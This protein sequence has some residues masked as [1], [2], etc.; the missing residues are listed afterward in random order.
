MQYLKK[1]ITFSAACVIAICCNVH[2]QAK[3]TN[4]SNFDVS[5]VS[6]ITAEELFEHAPKWCDLETC[7]LIIN[8][9][10]EYG[11][12]SEFAISVFT[13][14]YVPERNSVGGWKNENGSYAAY[15]S[16]QQSI[17]SWYENMSETYLNQESWHYSLTGSTLIK[18]IA[19]VYCQGSKEYS[20]KSKFWFEKINNLT[21]D[22][23]KSV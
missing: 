19:P 8:L 17:E 12:S 4:N 7:Q 2:C 3:E 20:E 5:V 6:D 1:A 18:D 23:E 22:I 15:D 16:L 9:S 14:E 21:L 11:I 13:Y 10:Q